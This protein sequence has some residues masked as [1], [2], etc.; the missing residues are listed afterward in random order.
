MLRNLIITGVAAL[1][2]AA[3]GLKDDLVRPS[4]I[5]PEDRQQQSDEQ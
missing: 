5:P 3:C 4:D 2:L 1:L